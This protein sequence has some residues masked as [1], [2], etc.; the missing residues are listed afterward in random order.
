MLQSTHRRL[1]SYFKTPSSG[2]R[3]GL[4]GRRRNYV[5]YKLDRLTRQVGETRSKGGMFK[6]SNGSQSAAKSSGAI[7]SLNRE[8]SYP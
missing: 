4:P 7:S 5:S 3:D 2:D 8:R 6:E 1:E